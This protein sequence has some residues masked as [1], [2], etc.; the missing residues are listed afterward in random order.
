M[1]SSNFAVKKVLMDTNIYGKLAIET[2]SEF[3]VGKL[4]IQN[5][6]IFYG[7][8]DLIR[9][10]LRAIPK[11]TKIDGKNF[12]IKTLSIYDVLIRN[13]EFSLDSEIAGLAKQYF[14]TYKKLGG[15][16]SKDEISNDFE[17]V[18]CA[19]LKNMDIL[20]SDDN[21]TMFS[22]EAKCSYDIVNFILKLKTPQQINYRE[23]IKL[24]I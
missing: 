14:E 8:K 6:F 7:I 4:L 15:S 16:F 3:I 12:R 18:A 23:L 9:K 21:R 19:T 17:I 2:K 20:V 22:S 11:L 1:K 24:L 10:E 5:K 13:H